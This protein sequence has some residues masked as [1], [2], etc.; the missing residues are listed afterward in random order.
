MSKCESNVDELIVPGLVGI[1]G[2][3]SSR[4][5]EY[6]DWHGDVQADVSDLET[7]ASNL[8]IQGQAITAIDFVNP[9]ARYSE[10]SFELGDDAVHAR[11]IEPVGRARVSKR[12]PLCLMFHDIDRPVRGWHHMTRFAAMG[13]AVLALD[14]ETI[15]S[16]DLQ[17]GITSPAF[18]E[19]VRWGCALAKVARNLD[20][21]DP[22]RIFAWGEGLAAVS[23]WRFLLWMSGALPARRLPIRFPA[24]SRRCRLGF[25]AR[26]SWAHHSWIP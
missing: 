21:M 1:P 26:C 16:N 8:E 12:V 15:G 25:V 9:C 23:R 18:V 2:T 20:G 6:R 3:V 19:R 10:I 7:C 24:V 22:D 14:D 4:L 17:Q 11:L 13:Y 5:A